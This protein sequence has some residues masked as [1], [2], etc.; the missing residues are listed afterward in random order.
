MLDLLPLST[1]YLVNYIT[2]PQDEE[3]EK[4][5]IYGEG[6]KFAGRAIETSS[7]VDRKVSGCR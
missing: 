3:F 6:K 5:T 4:E 2:Q 7:S 1:I